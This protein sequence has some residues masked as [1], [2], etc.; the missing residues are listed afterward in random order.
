MNEQ[1]PQLLSAKIPYPKKL[2]AEVNP[3][4][5]S[6]HIKVGRS[7]T[8]EELM[9]Y[10]ITYSDNEAALLLMKYI[11]EKMFVK[12]FTDLGIPAPDMK[13]PHI[14]ITA[15]DYSQ[16]WK[17]IYNAGYLNLENSEKCA[18]AA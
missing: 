12:L 3:L 15:K 18:V 1:I 7:Y 17:I 5:T 10:C 16:F 2:S 8:V 14:T 6:K 4:Y 11:D 13:A 9:K